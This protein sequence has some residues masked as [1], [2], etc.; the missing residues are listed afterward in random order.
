MESRALAGTIYRG[1]HGERQ[2]ASK[3]E[4]NSQVA[5]KPYF[6]EPGNTRYPRSADWGTAAAGT[7]ISVGVW[8]R[9]N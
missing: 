9:T 7:V 6:R 1:N 5:V 3:S 2:S 4:A 8:M